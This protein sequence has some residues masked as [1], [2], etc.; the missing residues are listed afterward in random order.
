MTRHEE[1]STLLVF[2]SSLG[3]I[4][5]R[6]AGKIVKGLAF[7]HPE[8]QSAEAV[9]GNGLRPSDPADWWQRSIVLRL[10]AF[11]EGVP[12][13]FRDI[14]IDP[15]ASTPFRR[16][17][18]RQCREI[19]YGETVSYAELAVRA[20]SPGAARAVG[21][22]MATNPVPLLIPCHRV[23]PAHGAPGHFSAPGG[24]EMKRRLL[25]LESP[26]GW[27]MPTTPRC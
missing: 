25:L 19:G 1:A 15:G 10:Q 12:M 21:N 17:V 23:L 5:L 26:V 24:T 6:A 2:A 11:A 4:A 27:A 7:G 8:A 3:W 22:C 14:A 9:I 16:R 13:D 20:G 18:L